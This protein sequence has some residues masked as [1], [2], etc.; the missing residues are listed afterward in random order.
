[1][2]SLSVCGKTFGFCRMR[3]TIGLSR[4]GGMPCSFA[5]GRE[6]ARSSHS[7]DALSRDEQGP[8]VDARQGALL[9]CGERRAFI[10]RG[11]I[12]LCPDCMFWL[13]L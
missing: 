8:T 1:M 4:P 3:Y 13:A 9:T 12:P 6:G 11:V 2:W 10:L 7:M 5:N